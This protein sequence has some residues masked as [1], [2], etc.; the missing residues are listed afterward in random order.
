[1]S[2][3]TQPSSPPPDQPPQPAETGDAVQM[4]G[5]AV[6]MTEEQLAEAKSYG[7]YDVVC[8]LADKA[9]DVAFLAVA[10]LLL[11][12]PL[13]RWLS[14]FPV[15]G[16]YWSLRLLVLFAIVTALHVCIS[17]PLSFYAGYVVEHRF[18]M[19]TLSLG[20]W[21]WR[22]LKRNLLALALGS[23]MM[24]GLYWL[25]WTTGWAWWLAAAGA[26]FFVAVLLGRLFPVLILPMFFKIEKL[27]RPE[28]DERIARLAQGTGLSIEGVY[29]IALSDETVK[30]NAMLAGLGRTRRV[31][32]GDT[33]LA[34]FSGDEIEVIFAH[35]IGHHV[36]GHIRKLIVAGIFSSA[37]G[38]FVCDQLLRVFVTGG[39]TASL[40]AG[41][42]VPDYK[43]MPVYTLPLV[44]LILTVFTMLLEPLQNFI[45]RGYE[46]QADRYALDR[47]GLH[48]AF[49]SAFRKLVRL[50]KDDPDPHWLD[51]LLFHSH[52]PISQRLAMAAG[53]NSLHH[54]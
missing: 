40:A 13:D 36:F 20:G 51:V 43:Q 24:L 7:R 4:T 53:R 31:L 5:D 35:E 50:N 22:Y 9:L 28:L 52:P 12:Q 11:S 49:V 17:A 15:L 21:L 3:E 38:F 29:R 42:T 19:S 25:I 47:T 39:G 14:G 2:D 44:M 8:A 41:G 48:D 46:R 1:M 33:L 26:F 37:A 10:A 27:D 54:K 34:G 45:S 16:S 23:V 18:Q 6:Q 30:A 32:L